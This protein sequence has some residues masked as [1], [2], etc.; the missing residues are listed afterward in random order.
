LTLL[1][2]SGPKQVPPPPQGGLT[3]AR[4]FFFFPPDSLQGIRTL[5]CFCP[6]S[7]LLTL[8]IFP[9]FR[10][11]CRRLFCRIR[12]VCFPG[13]VCYTPLNL[14]GP[15]LS[16]FHPPPFDSVFCV[17]SS[18][19]GLKRGLSAPSQGVTLPG[20]CPFFV[21]TTLFPRSSYC[22]SLLGG[23]R[24]ILFFFSH[25]TFPVSWSTNVHLPLPIPPLF[26]FHRNGM[27]LPSPDFYPPFVLPGRDLEPRGHGFFFF[28]FCMRNMGPCPGGSLNPGGLALGLLPE[29]SM[30]CFFRPQYVLNL[31]KS[32]KKG[33]SVQFPGPSETN[34]E[35]L[36]LCPPVG[37]NPSAGWDRTSKNP[38]PP[39]V[40]FCM[41]FKKASASGSTRRGLLHPP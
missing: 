27:I 9:Y 4:G 19:I 31:E 13:S 25:V 5:H 12:E 11:L 37:Q 17:S 8:A 7:W 15:H 20:P 38:C 24:F 29:A 36:C 21:S 26:F 22:I 1:L 14:D 33:H 6:F 18:G 30:M 2:P 40:L 41:L 28:F 10:K 23:G 16:F 3:G 39:R 34:G 35:V 32:L